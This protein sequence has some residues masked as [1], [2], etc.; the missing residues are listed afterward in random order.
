MSF[1]FFFFVFDVEVLRKMSSIA[2]CIQTFV[3]NSVRWK[4]NVFRHDSQWQ[5]LT[6]KARILIFEY[7]VCLNS[8]AGPMGF[9]AGGRST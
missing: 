3:A 8:R 5:M 6:R 9:V 4:K 2:H 7:A 1:L